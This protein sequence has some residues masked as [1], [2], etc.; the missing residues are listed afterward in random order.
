[1]FN[2]SG[3]NCSECSSS[4]EIKF[5]IESNVSHNFSK[6]LKREKEKICNLE[7]TDENG[8]LN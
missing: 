3:R 4:G 5:E 8:N 7:E 6:K 2:Y 1:M